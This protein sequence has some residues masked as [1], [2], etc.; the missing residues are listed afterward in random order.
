[1]RIA[2]VVE[3]WT[4]GIATYIR[5]LTTQQIELGHEVILVCDRRK[6][7]G[8]VP[9]VPIELVDYISSRKP[10][11]F[12][13]IANE[14][15]ELICESKADVVH[16]HSSFPGLYVRLRTHEG[17]RI[18]YT[19]HAWS[20]LKKDT[21]FV[22]RLLYGAVE[23]ALARRCSIIFCMSFDEIR[24]AQK[25][26]IPSEK[27]EFVYTGITEDEEVLKNALAL[28]LQ[29]QRPVT[30]ESI[31]VG[32]F[33]R[34]DYQKGFDVL[35]EAVPFLEA[36][37][38]IHVFGAAVRKGVQIAT[39]PQLYYHGW[40]DSSLTRGAMNEMDVIVVPS[41]WEGLAL[42]PIEAMRAGKVVV[43][44]NQSSLPEQ[45]IH[46]YNGIILRE[47]TGKRLAEQLNV[48]TA[49]ECKR[50]GENARHVFENVFS[51]GKFISS[52]MRAYD[53]V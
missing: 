16:C 4:G 14:L 42:V 29:P 5:T 25:Y 52:L 20:F 2:H 11:H 39:M 21:R 3:A 28:K 31:K 45:V 19:P 41:R 49:E 27:I 35:L 37:V 30:V 12:F 48:L 26:G 15:R 6:L 17:V 33:G 34:L 40:L 46:G 9:P 53:R 18:L 22:S 50:M 10:W 44:S 47:L 13:S 32:Y 36:H 51:I 38:E 24:A 43:V 7:D 1:M 23:R 8:W